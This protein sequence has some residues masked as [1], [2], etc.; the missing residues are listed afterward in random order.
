[1][2]QKILNIICILLVLAIA[3]TFIW[4]F[5]HKK[6]LSHEAYSDGIV[7]VDLNSIY[8][9]GSKIQVDFSDVLVS[10]HDETRK[11][12][13]STQEAT[14]QTKLTDRLVQNFD[15]DFMKKTQTV[16][17]TGKG[18]FV[19]D[20][21]DLTK[22]N[23]IEDKKNKTITIQINHAHL[24]TVEIDPSQVIIDDV[25]ESLLAKGDIELTLKDYNTIEKELVHRLEEKF[26]T[27]E[28]GQEA[29][30]IALQMVKEIYEPL[31]T[32]INPNYML[33]VEFID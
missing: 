4:G 19:V 3:A 31:V 12:I 15:F 30:T 6:T 27:A 13:V 28:N 10:K 16:S 5:V 14:V 26:N 33:Y 24:E 8:L 1:M 18:Y 17:Y 25:K 32:A 22:E 20:L 9:E 7:Q 23:I 2:K 21:D 11:L 29:D